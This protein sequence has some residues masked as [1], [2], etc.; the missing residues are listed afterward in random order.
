MLYSK[1][2]YFYSYIKETTISMNERSLLLSTIF[3]IKSKYYGNN[4]RLID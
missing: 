2:T 3:T 1:P 4:H